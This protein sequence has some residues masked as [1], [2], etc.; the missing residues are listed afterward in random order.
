[1]KAKQLKEQHPMRNTPYT[2]VQI[3]CDAQTPHDTPHTASAVAI[4]AISA[5]KHL[6]T[7]IARAIEE[8]IEDPHAKPYI[9]RLRQDAKALGLRLATHGFGTLISYPS[10]RRLYIKGTTR[11]WHTPKPSYT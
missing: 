2:M 7:R 9:D 4:L 5:P 1:M 10:G 3:T 8:G 11:K 6:A